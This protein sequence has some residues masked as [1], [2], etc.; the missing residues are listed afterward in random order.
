M[1]TE[2]EKQVLEE[3]GT[4]SPQTLAG[5]KR[6]LDPIPMQGIETILDGLKRVRAVLEKLVARGLLSS[7]PGFNTEYSITDKGMRELNS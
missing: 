3:L 1:L 6:N 2:T 4:K 5:L 7:K